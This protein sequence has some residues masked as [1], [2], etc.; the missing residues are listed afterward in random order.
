MTVLDWL[1]ILEKMAVFGVLPGAVCF[2]S[3]YVVCWAVYVLEAQPLASSGVEEEYVRAL[4]ATQESR[5]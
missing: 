4:K 3:A 1:V 5:E 2:L